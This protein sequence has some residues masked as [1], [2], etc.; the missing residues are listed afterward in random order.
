MMF[1]EILMTTAVYIYFIGGQGHSWQA[2]LQVV[3]ACLAAED[4]K[5]KP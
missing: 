2:V 1:Y 4:L 5:R 3:S